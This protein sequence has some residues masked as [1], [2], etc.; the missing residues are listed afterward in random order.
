MVK[1]AELQ[2]PQSGSKDPEECVRAV[3]LT[4]VLDGSQ[5]CDLFSMS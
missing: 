5:P 1:W 4:A 3:M 2:K